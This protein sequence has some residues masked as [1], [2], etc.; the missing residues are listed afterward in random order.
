MYFLLIERRKIALENIERA[1]GNKKSASDK[2]KIVVESF[3]NLAISFME[4][5]RM[6]KTLRE[7]KNRFRIV[8]EEHV[9][10]AFAR[11]KGIIF[12]ISH[13]GSWEY[14]TFFP[15]LKKFP[16]AVIGRTIR[17]PYLHRWVKS[18][19]NQS[20]LKHIEKNKA[21]W[22][23]LKELKKN[24]AVAI[25]IDQW[26][27]SEGLWIDFFGEGTSTT[28]LPAR[29]ARKTGCALIPGYC[30]RIGDGRYEM[31]FKPEVLLQTNDAN[32]E[33]AT[34]R[35]LNHLLEEEILLHPEQ[36]TWA[37][38]RW[39]QR[40]TSQGTQEAPNTQPTLL[41]G[42]LIFPDIDHE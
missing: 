35:E 34:T 41:D 5:F 36:W 19:R 32:W 17:N 39:K 20:Q 38:R 23:I 40:E 6:P 29:L 2:R 27:G 14:L 31:K 18:L 37:H 8:G 30:L 21:I 11:G 7:P 22:P 3:G 12:V 1:F 42:Q 24:H 9:D 33:E 28:S 26:A 16:C 4:L 15:Y 25:L 10:R 13:L